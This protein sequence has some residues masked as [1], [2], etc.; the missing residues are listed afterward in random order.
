VGISCF[1]ALE[2]ISESGLANDN[3]YTSRLVERAPLFRVERRDSVPAHFFVL[4]EAQFI[5]ISPPGARA[6]LPKG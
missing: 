3:K 2:M 4:H 1:R 6:S 5:S